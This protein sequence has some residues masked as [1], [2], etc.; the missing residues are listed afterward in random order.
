MD[1]RRVTRSGLS[2]EQV[3]YLIESGDFTPK[4][5]ADAQ[6]RVARG[7]LAA[8]ERATR[9]QAIDESLGL[10]EVAELLGAST[11]DVDRRRVDGALFAFRANHEF[12]YPTWQFT[13]DPQRPVLP[14]L[15]RLVQALPTDWPPAGIRG[16]MLTPQRSARIDG[17]PATPVEWLVA[18]GDPQVLSDILNSFLQS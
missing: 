17:V 15:E 18:G 10:S 2:P 14:G 4:E 13:G 16:F 5:L 6:A 12:R 11:E 3:D 7:D 9:Q 8:E 1:E